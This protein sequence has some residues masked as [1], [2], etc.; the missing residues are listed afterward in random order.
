MYSLNC[1]PNFKYEKINSFKKERYFNFLWW[2]F[3][4]PLIQKRDL[5]LLFLR[6]NIFDM[7]SIFMELN[8]RVTL[9]KIN[10]FYEKIKSQSPLF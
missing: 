1:N 8:E 4:S 9:I 7:N 5:F 3:S 10:I 6:L 2:E